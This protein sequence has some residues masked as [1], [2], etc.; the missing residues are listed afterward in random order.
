[1]DYT[2]P[3]YERF[4]VQYMKN[5]NAFEAVHIL[6][7]FKN[8]A[9]MHILGYY[10]EDIRNIPLYFNEQIYKLRISAW[11]DKYP[12]LSK[13]LQSAYEE[14]NEKK[15][16]YLDNQWRSAIRIQRAWRRYKA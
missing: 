7:A 10:L 8:E 13:A 4:A 9:R 6:D 3:R 1:M 14:A 2:L 5:P 15:N 16:W 12:Q 11:K